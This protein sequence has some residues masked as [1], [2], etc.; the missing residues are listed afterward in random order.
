MSKMYQVS[1]LQALALGYFK[2]VV[3]VEELLRHGDIGLGTFEDLDGE[4]IVVDG[5]CYQA[6]SDGSVS[7][8]PADHGVPFAAVGFLG[9]ESE[10]AAGVPGDMPVVAVGCSGNEANAAVDFLGVRPDA[11]VGFLGGESETD[12][13]PVENEEALKVLLDNKIEEAFGLNS[14]HVARIDGE[15]ELVDARSADVHPSQ[16]VELKEVLGRTQKNFRFENID[17]SLICVYYPD[18]MDGINASGWHFHFISGDRRRGGHVFGVKIRSGRLRISRMDS[19]EI[20]LPTD[21]AFDTY[22]LKEASQQD[23]KEVEQKG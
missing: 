12:L 1:T 18:Y 2:E 14:I 8:T 6:F 11:A 21:P 23:I 17:G 22:A 19:L 13:G 7:E 15:F 3:T 4:M 10:T 5:R 20:Q 16:H 9:G